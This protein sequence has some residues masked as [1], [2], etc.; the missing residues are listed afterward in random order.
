M[1][2]LAVSPLQEVVPYRVAAAAVGPDGRLTPPHL[3]RLF[4]E[5]AMRNT[6]RLRLSSPELMADFGLSWVLRRQRVRVERLPA[7]GETGTVVTAPTGFARRLLTYR[8]FYLLD[9]DG[10]QLAAASSEWLL[11]HLKSRR[12][13]P[14]PDHILAI[15]PD[16]APASAQLERPAGNV[17]PP[18]S[19][20]PTADFRVAYHQL[21]FND[22]LTNP[23]FPELML[24]PLGHAF[25][26]AHSPRLLDVAYHLEARYG[27]ALTAQ[28]GPPNGDRLAYA[29][30]LR[31]GADVL[32]TM[33]TEWVPD[34]TL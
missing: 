19:D 8:D 30:A 22:H 25:L 15:Q 4:Q 16:L 27:D 32:A 26:T 6:V 11:L 3:I 20:A 9:E 17:S 33:R 23:V 29:H 2:P 14:I 34:G 31:R 10:C 24:E 28:A 13:H 1:N 21:D 5:A 7:M 12:P 18:P